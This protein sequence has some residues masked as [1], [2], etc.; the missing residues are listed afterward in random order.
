[1]CDVPPPL[2][3]E[4]ELEFEQHKQKSIHL[5]FGVPAQISKSPNLNT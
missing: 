4:G 1:M 3:K 2:Y 5:H